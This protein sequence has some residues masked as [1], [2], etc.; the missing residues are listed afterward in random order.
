MS[1]SHQAELIEQ[2]LGGVHLS[3]ANSQ[4]GNNVGGDTS[5]HLPVGEGIDEG[6]ESSSWGGEEVEE[7]A[8][9]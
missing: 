5:N 4:G 2:M 6:G 9:V 7:E 3:L 8:N 1:L